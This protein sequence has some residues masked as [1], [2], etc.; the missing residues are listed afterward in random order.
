MERLI[1]LLGLQLQVQ[2]KRTADHTGNDVSTLLSL[3]TGQ[4][5]LLESLQDNSAAGKLAT[6]TVDGSKPVW[7]V[8]L[9]RNPRFVGREEALEA[10]EDELTKKDEN[11]AI[12]ALYGLGGVGYVTSL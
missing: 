2:A 9:S 8:P 12:A 1:Q 10:L 3:Q 6:S 4:L 7:I 11:M 5:S